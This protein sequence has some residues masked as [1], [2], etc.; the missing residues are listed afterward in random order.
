LATELQDQKDQG[1]KSGSKELPPFELE[2]SLLQETILVVDGE[3]S[4]VMLLEHMLRLEGF[5]N[6]ISVTDS[7]EV[8]TIYREHEIDLVLL[9]I[10]M[11]YMDGFQVMEELNRV[12]KGDY[13][14]I[15][16]L[17]AQI[18]RETCHR[19]LKT[20]AMDFVTKPFESVEVM[21]RIRNLL[22]V[23]MYY[24]RSRDQNLLL[25]G[26]VAERTAQLDQRN[27]ELEG[28]NNRLRRLVS[29]RISLAAC[30]NSEHVWRLLLE[31]LTRDM[32]AEGGGIYFR[33]GDEY[34]LCHT[35]DRLP[36]PARVPLPLAVGTVF[37]H[38]AGRCKPLMLSGVSG[39]L[40]DMPVDGSRSG[41]NSVL[42]LPLLDPEGECFGILA[43]KSP[44]EHDFTAQDREMATILAAHSCVTAH[45]I[46]ATDEM[47]AAKEEAE[48]A[49][50]AKSEFL[51]NT[52]HEL[53]TPLNA[54]IGFSEIMWSESFGPI[55]NDQYKGYV[56]DIYDSGRHLLGVIN[57]ILDM[58]RIEAGREELREEELDVEEIVQTSI[59]FVE[60]RAREGGLTL[61]VEVADYLP[62][63]YADKR[64]IRQ[65]LLNLLSNAVKFTPTG[66]SVSVVAELGPGGQMVIA[67][68]DTGI[69]I[70]PQD[71]DR[72]LQPFGQVDGA[73]TRKYEGTGLGLPLSRSLIELHGGVLEL[74]SE[75][76]SG[77]RIGMLLPAERVRTASSHN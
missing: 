31:E 36:R 8:T 33:D 34:V 65:I 7:R 17:T 14:P 66:G 73:L 41:R 21:N 45:A 16:V 49:T 42:A 62:S 6:V 37:E 64:K 61:E 55:E 29:T 11:P 67:V 18:D 28:L 15:L 1:E 13:L 76:G 63:L 75:V 19:A 12:T 32:P 60:Q 50:R 25:E 48:I 69:G 51:T 74:Q 77:T 2:Q 4:N 70:A 5:T 58:S 38:V 30:E 44:V 23:R 24:K 43:L 35:L 9:D 20:G 26:K 59:R 53:R 3:P 40:E 56:R 72:A 47:R 22:G 71:V 10:N 27:T 46:E 54:I 52:T 68:Q 39:P 57:D